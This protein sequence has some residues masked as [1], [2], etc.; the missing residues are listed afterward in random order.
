MAISINWSTGVIT[1]PKADT[2]QIQA[3]PEIRTL[4]IDTFRLALKDLEDE[5]DG[6]AFPTTHN[7]VAPITVGGTVLARVVEILPPY[8]VTFEASTPAYRLDLINANSNILDRTNYTTTQVTSA[9]S[10]GLANV[11]QLAAAVAAAVDQSAKLVDIF[12]RLDLDIAVPNTHKNDNTEITN[13]EFDLTT[14]DNGDGTYTV[15]RTNNP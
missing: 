5:V 3:S 7:H 4:D 15:T 11:D 12:R 1:V 8:T 9:N 13:S 14:T 10:A 6:I 2:V